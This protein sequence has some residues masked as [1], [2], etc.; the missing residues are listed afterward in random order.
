MANKQTQTDKDKGVRNTEKDR[1]DDGRKRLTNDGR[2][3][4]NMR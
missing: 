3:R 1:R 4:V 2:K